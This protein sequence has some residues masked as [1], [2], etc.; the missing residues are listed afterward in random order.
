ML[1]S[2]KAY[3]GRFSRRHA[4]TSPRSSSGRI[5]TI[6]EI[7]RSSESM[8]NHQDARFDKLEALIEKGFA[9][10]KAELKDTHR[11]QEAKDARIAAFL[12]R[13]RESVITMRA[14][15]NDDK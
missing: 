5:S 12:E 15:T 2:G 4:P 1:P 7:G 8:E 11:Q 13:V 10:I 14:V 9:D 6:S 3:C